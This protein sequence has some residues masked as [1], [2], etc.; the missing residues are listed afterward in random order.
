[1]WRKNVFKIYFV[2]I[3]K[4]GLV[5][6]WIGWWISWVENLFWYDNNKHLEGHIFAA[7]DSND[8]CGK[9][10][11]TLPVCECL[12]RGP[13]V[14]PCL[15]NIYYLTIYKI[16]GNRGLDNYICLSAVRLPLMTDNCFSK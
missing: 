6:G 16:L 3:P 10:V 5:D 9:V 8:T 15:F 1:M 2:V 4:E 7:R 11:Q 12:A 13:S 14:N